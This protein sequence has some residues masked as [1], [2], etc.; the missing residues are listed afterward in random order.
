MINLT[1]SPVF[2]AQVVVKHE[3]WG[4]SQKVMSELRN[5]PMDNR[6]QGDPQLEDSCTKVQSLVK[7][8]WDSQVTLCGWGLGTKG[9]YGDIKG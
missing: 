6:V 8:A 9:R 2:E 3:N 4:I 5:F 1:F 7:A